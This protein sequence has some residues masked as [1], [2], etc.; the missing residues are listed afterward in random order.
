MKMIMAWALATALFFCAC[1]AGGEKLHEK[2]NGSWKNDIMTVEY[3]FKGGVTRG[4]AL[5]QE[6]EKKLSLVKEYGNVVVFMSGDSKITGQ[7][8]EDGSIMLTKEGGLPVVFK[9]I[10]Q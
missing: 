7:F 5:G 10:S 4:V 9:K 3:D 8:Q 2:L 6:Y 1:S